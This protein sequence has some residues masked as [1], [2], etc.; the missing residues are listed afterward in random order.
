MRLCASCGEEQPLSEF[1][2]KKKSSDGL[3][4]HCK[5]CKRKQHR[6]YRK[7]NRVRLLKKKAEYRAANREAISRGHKRYYAENIDK[8]KARDKRYYAENKE[9][10]LE[11]QRQSGSKYYR[12]N[13]DKF[14][15]KW[16]RR[17]AKTKAL[18]ATLTAEQWE[19]IKAEYNYSC[20]YCGKGW[21]ELNHVLEQEHVI[22]VS[23]GGGYT[24]ENIV[25]SCRDCNRKKHARTPEQ[26]GMKLRKPMLSDTVG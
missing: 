11:R 5:S 22:P 15:A 18:P 24:A 12:R 7:T 14:R 9:K 1:T 10:I 8:I 17:Y 3:D 6:N 20:A 19:A 26:A 4:W 25:P 13:K 2:K 21:H 16:A 23:Q